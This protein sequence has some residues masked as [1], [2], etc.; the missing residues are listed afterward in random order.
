[1]VQFYNLYPLLCNPLLAE[2]WYQ[3]KKPPLRVVFW[4]RFYDS[5]NVNPSLSPFP[6]PIQERG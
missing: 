2:G 4:T 1:M 5:R 3:I 6:S